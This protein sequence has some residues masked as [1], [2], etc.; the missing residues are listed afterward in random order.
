[1]ITAFKERSIDKAILRNVIETKQ[2]Q[3]HTIQN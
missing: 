2:D 3:Y 1:M